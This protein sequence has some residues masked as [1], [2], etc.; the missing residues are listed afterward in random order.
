VARSPLAKPAPA[1][2]PPP[3]P[4]TEVAIPAPKP[5]LEDLPVEELVAM[6]EAKTGKKT[7]SRRPEYLIGLI[8]G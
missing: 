8:R 6:A 2:P 1:A 3:P 4:R 5:R 7:R